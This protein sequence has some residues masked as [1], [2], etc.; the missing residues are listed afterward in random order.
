MGLSIP[1]AV[2]AVYEKGGLPPPSLRSPP[3]DIFRARKQADADVYNLGVGL[4][5]R[6]ADTY[7]WR[8]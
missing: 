7:V 6:C 3:E 5:I 1:N 2:R 4:L 8:N